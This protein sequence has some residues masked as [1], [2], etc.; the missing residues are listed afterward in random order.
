M[1]MRFEIVEYR[2]RFH[3]RVR[4]GKMVAFRSTDFLSEE[5]CRQAIEELKR[6]RWHLA[7]VVRV[8]RA[9]K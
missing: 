6:V 1:S 8:V 9:V 5:K 3:W 2:G 7:E 4:R